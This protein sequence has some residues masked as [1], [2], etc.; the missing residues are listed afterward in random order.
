MLYAPTHFTN[1]FS[2]VMIYKRITKYRRGR[3]IRQAGITKKLGRPGKKDKVR[4][5][6]YPTRMVLKL[7]DS[8]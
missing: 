5:R 1:N 3:N 7:K 4:S 2:K 6:A 8:A